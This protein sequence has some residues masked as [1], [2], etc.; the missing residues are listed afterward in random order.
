MELS[1]YLAQLEKTLS[2]QTARKGKLSIDKRF[3][4][5]AIF[6]ASRESGVGSR[7][8]EKSLERMSTKQIAIRARETKTTK[9]CKIKK[10][11]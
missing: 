3:S 6:N 11:W 1:Q 7:E 8:H 5:W 2:L 9:L 10:L 4:S